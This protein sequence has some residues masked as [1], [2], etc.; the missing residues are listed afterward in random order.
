MK[1]PLHAK[2]SRRRPRPPLE[3]E[4][5]EPRQLLALVG[6]GNEALLNQ[7]ATG[8]QFSSGDALQ[9]LADG[10]LIATYY[11]AGTG[12][13]SGVFLRRYDAAGTPAAAALVNTTKSGTQTDSVVAANG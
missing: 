1:S 10:R 4:P 2:K 11:G 6:V 12:D 9:M 5:L 7:V 13:T 8:N 3:V